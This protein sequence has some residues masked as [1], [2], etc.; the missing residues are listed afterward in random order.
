MELE[1]SHGLRSGRQNT[2]LLDFKGSNPPP[3]PTSPHCK[4]HFSFS[5]HLDQLSGTKTLSK[6]NRALLRCL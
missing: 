3:H 1:R 2:H 6:D 4:D 5:I